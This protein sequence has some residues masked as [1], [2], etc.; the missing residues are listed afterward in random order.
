LEDQI[1]ALERAPVPTGQPGQRT[2]DEMRAYRPPAHLVAGMHTVG[3]RPDG[4]LE[5]LAD[6]AQRAGLP[7]W[8][9]IGFIF[10][11]CGR[12]P[13]CVNW[14]LREHYRCPTTQDGKNRIFRGGE[15]LP[16]PRRDAGTAPVA[17]NL[18]PTPLGRPTVQACIDILK[19]DPVAKQ[20]IRSYLSMLPGGIAG[21]VRNFILVLCDSFTPIEACDP[22]APNSYA[23]QVV[24]TG[25]AEAAV[26]AIQRQKGRVPHLVN[27]DSH[28]RYRP[29]DHTA[30]RITVQ[31]SGH[32]PAAYVLDW[33]ASLD[34]DH[35]WVS[36]QQQFDDGQ[37]GQLFR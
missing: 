28:S 16:L 34:I 18:P 20:R 31:S 35:P 3:R 5:S 21:G 27:I 32:A 22:S 4:R 24:C 19:S 25:I 9:Y 30:V 15:R 11:G 17:G 14:Y 23:N 12:K 2:V 26:S 36:T 13:E 33:W 7:F 10:P 29:I 8:D 37:R 1:M 6:V